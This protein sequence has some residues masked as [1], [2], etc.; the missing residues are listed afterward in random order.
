VPHTTGRSA[1]F[2]VTATPRDE[3]LPA[4]TS[5]FT[6]TVL[7]NLADGHYVTEFVSATGERA[8][9][10][11]LDAGDEVRIE[12]VVS[13]AGTADESARRVEPPAVVVRTP[14][15]AGEAIETSFVR[16]LDLTIEIDGIEA[17][18]QVVFVGRAQRVPLERAS[19]SVPAG[20]FPDALRY[21]TSGDGSTAFSLGL[22]AVQIALHAQGSE[23]FAQNVGLVV[24]R[25]SVTID[26]SATTASGDVSTAS[27][28][29]DLT[30]ERL[31]DEGEPMPAS[32]ELSNSRRKLGG[33][34]LRLVLR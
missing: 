10:I 25:L 12:Q 32:R 8:R 20:T 18:R 34:G 13:N 16:I 5:G 24:E 6:S 33:G 4:E 28:S 31:A 1:R 19:V 26:V 2:R 17:T 30:T 11:A 7:E 27:S 14:V 15:V 21:A 3:T 22:V 9:T 23:S 29:L